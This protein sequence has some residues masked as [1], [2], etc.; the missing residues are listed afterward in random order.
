MKIYIKAG[1]LLL[2]ISF[3]LT[4][5]MTQGASKAQNPVARNAEPHLISSEFSF[6]EGPAADHAGNIYFTDQPNDKIMKWSIDGSV[7]T[8]M[9]GAGRSNGLYVDHSGNLIA[10]ADENN[11]LWKIDRN[12]KVEVLLKDFEGKRLN[13]PNDLWIDPKGNIY[14]T[15]PYYKRDYWKHNVK[16]I[17]QQ[18]VYFFN[19][20]QHKVM[21]VA[22]DLLQP[23]GIIGTRD[24]KK[25]YVTDIN[26]KKTYVYQIN[27]D[28]SLANKKL[29]CSL[30]S[31]GMTIDCKGNVYLTGRGVTVFN[32]N[33]IQIAQIPINEPWTA[34][35]TFGGKKRKTLFI[36][37]SKS[38]YSLDMKVKGI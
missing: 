18:R 1:L 11:Q 38:I 32:K 22:N 28:G 30:G 10:C 34:N 9:E 33:G 7:S 21:I 35:V 15:D 31:D 24:G 13:G 8:F 12:K 29:F 25:L 37:A 4:T 5:G 14:F 19:L 16:E 27:S 17:D 6:T 2:L 26:D 36:T 3:G 23:N 20:V